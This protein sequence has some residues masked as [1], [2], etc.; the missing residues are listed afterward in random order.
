M[1]FFPVLAW[2]RADCAEMCNRRDY[3][4]C[5]DFREGFHVSEQQGELVCSH[6]R[7]VIGSCR[8]YLSKVVLSLQGC[9][10]PNL[11]VFMYSCQMEKKK[12]KKK[13]WS[14]YFQ[15]SRNLTAP[16]LSRTRNC[17]FLGGAISRR[18]DSGSC[19]LLNSKNPAAAWANRGA[20]HRPSL[21]CWACAL[22]W[23][24]IV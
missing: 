9:S 17:C 10:S 15:L 3:R 20:K 6:I 7:V 14:F 8:P 2:L 16:E 4:Q 12:E 13:K 21:S 23:G 1:C 18:Q 5:S 24:S 19:L 22:D 11:Q